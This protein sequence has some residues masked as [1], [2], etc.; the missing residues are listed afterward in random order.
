[1]R[2]FAELLLDPTRIAGE[3]A[4]ALSLPELEAISEA[5]VARCPGVGMPIWVR[6]GALWIECRVVHAHG[7]S[8]AWWMHAMTLDGRKAY[9][10]LGSGLENIDW[11]TSK[12]EGV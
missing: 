9:D 6:E 12:P 3:E 1:V 4:R 7:T 10:W 2:T 8:R 11:R 5:Q